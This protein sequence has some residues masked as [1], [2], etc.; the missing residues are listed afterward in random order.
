[1]TQTHYLGSKLIF[2]CFYI[3]IAYFKYERTSNS[4]YSKKKS[5][6]KKMNC[7]IYIGLCNYFIFLGAFVSVSLFRENRVPVA[8]SGGTSLCSR[9]P[10][11]PSFQ[12]VPVYPVHPSPLSSHAFP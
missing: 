1:M 5:S 12:G 9:L 2:G 10:R 6:A 4:K 7:I 11:K 3:Y 8:A